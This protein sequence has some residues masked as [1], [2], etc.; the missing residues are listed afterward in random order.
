MRRRPSAARATHDGSPSGAYEA[1][2]LRVEGPAWDQVLHGDGVVAGTEALRLVERVRL[3]DLGHVGLD[4]EP[5]TV[6]HAHE[7]AGD[8]E[9][10]LREALAVLPDPVRVD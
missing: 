10:L 3:L 2:L 1:R 6:R 4:A 7:P 8:A 9:R 5:R